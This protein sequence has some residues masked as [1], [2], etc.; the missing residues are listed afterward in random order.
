[1]KSINAALL[2]GKWSL[3]SF[4]LKFWGMQWNWGKHAAG[5]I[6]YGADGQMK[7]DVK[8]EKSIFPSIAG[9]IF[10]NVLAYG[11]SYELQDKLVV[12]HLDYCSQKSWTGK[13]Q[14]REILQ[15]DEEH[16]C[17]RAATKRF[18]TP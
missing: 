6:V 5:W 14:V 8:A 2:L 3:I 1:M 12:H 16:W 18:S 7:V 10:N 13:D 17:Y 4:R 15:L 9:L 11:G